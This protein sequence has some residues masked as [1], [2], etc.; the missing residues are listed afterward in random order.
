MRFLVKN[1]FLVGYLRHEYRVVTAVFHTA[2]GAAGT[3]HPFG[4]EY[5]SDLVRV[6]LTAEV[7]ESCSALG[8][9]DMLAL[10]DDAHT[11]GVEF[12]DEKRRSVSCYV[13]VVFRA[14]RVNEIELIAADE[15]MLLG[16]VVSDI[17][18]VIEA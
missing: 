1:L 13:T 8:Y 2:L 4:N 9:C 12:C 18:A 17:F 14:A 11:L 7:S 3:L 5:V 10:T 6:G 16:I 15:P